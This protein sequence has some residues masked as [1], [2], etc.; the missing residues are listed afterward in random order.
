[1][2]FLDSAQVDS[3]AFEEVF[4]LFLGIA[5]VD[6]H[7]KHVERLSRRW[8]GG[9]VV[10]EHLVDHGR[11]DQLLSSS[12]ALGFRFSIIPLARDKELPDFFE[13]GFH[14]GLGDLHSLERQWLEVQI[15][16]VTARLG[17]LKQQERVK[18]YMVRRWMEH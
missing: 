11:N 6:A 16:V 12:G 15:F 5:F 14:R 8:K 18:K 7:L 13:V 10:L 3:D 4:D 17:P 2:P 9:N 1:M